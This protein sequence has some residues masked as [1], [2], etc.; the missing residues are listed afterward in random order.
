MLDVHGVMVVDAVE[1]VLNDRANVHCGTHRGGSLIPVLV[2][3]GRFALRGCHD[4]ITSDIINCLYVRGPKSRQKSKQT[5]TK[6]SPT[7]TTMIGS[8]HGSETQRA[9]GGGS[10]L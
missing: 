3:I 5:G 1:Q 2:Y 6:G 9:E 8:S 4:A 7:A 10:R